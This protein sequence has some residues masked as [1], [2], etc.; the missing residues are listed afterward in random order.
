VS[1]RTALAKIERLQPLVAGLKR[2]YLGRSKTPGSGRPRV[3]AVGPGGRTDSWPSVKNPKLVTGSWLPAQAGGG[4]SGPRHRRR[5][6]CARPAQT[7]HSRRH[8]LGGCTVHCLA[9]RYQRL[10]TIVERSTE[11]P[12]AFVEVAFVSIPFSRPKARCRRGTRRLIATNR[13][14]AIPFPS[15][16]VAAAV[17]AS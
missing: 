8:R 3:D 2:R 6:H 17:H 7:V 9:S 11:Y 10:N 13:H 5:G 16:M 4:R 14:L 1:G 12:I 15:C